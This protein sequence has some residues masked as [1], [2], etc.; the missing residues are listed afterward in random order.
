[1]TMFNKPSL[2]YTAYEHPN[3]LP[4]PKHCTWVCYYNSWFLEA[5]VIIAARATLLMH[6]CDMATIFSALGHTNMQ[7][8]CH[9]YRTTTMEDTQTPNPSSSI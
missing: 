8:E 3:S 9:P 7:P 2:R 4:L 1:M 5:F 6:Y